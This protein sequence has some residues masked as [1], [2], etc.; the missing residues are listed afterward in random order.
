MSISSCQ[1]GWKATSSIRW[2]KRS[3][4]FSSGLFLSASKPAAIARAEPASAP[5]AVIVSS[6]KSPPSRETASRRTRSE[7]KTL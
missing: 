2:P 6:A 3:K 1:A 5:I 4:I 7:L